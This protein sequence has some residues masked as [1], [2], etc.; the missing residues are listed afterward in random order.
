MNSIRALARKLGLPCAA[1][2]RAPSP[3]FRGV[4]SHDPFSSRVFAVSA[5]RSMYLC[6]AK[7]RALID[8]DFIQ[9]LSA[10]STVCWLLT[11]DKNHQKEKQKGG[12]AALKQ[13]YPLK[14][15]KCSAAKGNSINKSL[16]E[17]SSPTL[18]GVPVFSIYSVV[19]GEGAMHTSKIFS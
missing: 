14:G 5:S 8:A 13:K 15:C 16:E 1:E 10:I 3:P 12:N 18:I 6:Q 19:Y 2:S 11:T 7:H 9:Q 17:L 4:K